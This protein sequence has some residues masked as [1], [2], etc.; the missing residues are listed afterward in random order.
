[1][2]DGQAM[3]KRKASG[4]LEFSTKTVEVCLD[5]SGVVIAEEWR[6]AATVARPTGGESGE[7]VA[8][9]HGLTKGA[10]VAIKG[11][12]DPGNSKGV[13][14]NRGLTKGADMAIRGKVDPGNRE[15]V[16]ANHGLTKGAELKWQKEGLPTLTHYEGY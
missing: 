9:N 13:A 3:A 8:A 5:S 10:D 16:T 6:E 4:L 7:G 12:A 2:T 14:A 15:G 1:M 11:K